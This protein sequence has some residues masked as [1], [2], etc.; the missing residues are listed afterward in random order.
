MGDS[1]EIEHIDTAV[2]VGV[3]SAAPGAGT[4]VDIVVIVE[5]SPAG[6]IVAVGGAGINVETELIGTGL[7]STELAIAI[8]DVR[9]IGLGEDSGPLRRGAIV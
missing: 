3:R 9:V 1:G 7:P 6:M 2:M 8:G 5:L 4:D